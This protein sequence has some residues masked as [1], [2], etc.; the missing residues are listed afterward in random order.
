MSICRF[1][2]IKT[3]L[4]CENNYKNIKFPFCE[5]H[6]KSGTALLYSIER[7]KNKIIN[8]PDNEEDF[9]MIKEIPNNIKMLDE[10]KPEENKQEEIKPEEIKLDDNKLEEIKPEENK[11]DEEILQLNNIGNLKIDS[12]DEIYS[13]DDDDS[14]SNKSSDDDYFT[15]YNENMYYSVYDNMDED[16]I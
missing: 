14:C 6:E 1:V 2:T 11:P 12:L 7:K 16:S 3:G 8:L 4:R 5:I 9:S 15:N 13:D 10:T